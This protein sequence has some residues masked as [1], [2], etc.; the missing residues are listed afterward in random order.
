[1]VSARRWRGG[2]A[3]DLGDDGAE[4]EQDLGLLPGWEPRGG[5]A[6]RGG[7]AELAAPR[8][9]RSLRPERGGRDR[10]RAHPHVSGPVEFYRLDREN[11][12]L[13]LAASGG[14]YLSHTIYSRNLDAVR[15][16]DLDGLGPWELLLP[17]ASY[18]ALEA[19]RRTKDGVETVWRLPLGGTL[20][21]NLA[22]TTDSE[23]RLMLAVGTLEGKLRIWR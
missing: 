11:G 10:R 23:D 2:V 16:G 6:V 19:V 8:R 15:A 5:G 13:W 14:E 20:A 18:T 17:D 21:T 22:S 1:M 7:A 9:S 4:G 3:G 12:E